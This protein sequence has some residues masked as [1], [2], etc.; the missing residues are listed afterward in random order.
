[1][2]PSDNRHTIFA[3]L[4]LTALSTDI[5]AKHSCSPFPRPRRVPSF[6]GSPSGVDLLL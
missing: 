1:M 3:A 6:W 2:I 4:F 5:S